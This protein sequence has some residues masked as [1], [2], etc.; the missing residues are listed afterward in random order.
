MFLVVSGLFSLPFYFQKRDI[1]P[2][3]VKITVA[4][5]QLVCDLN[6]FLKPNTRPNLVIERSCFQF[7][8]KKLLSIYMAMMLFQCYLIK[9]QNYC[10]SKADTLYF[11]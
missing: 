6:S 10:C 3:E 7:G 4:F 8:K 9:M 1:R 2:T 5:M 11:M